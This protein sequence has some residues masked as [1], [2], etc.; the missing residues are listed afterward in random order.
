MWKT[1]KVIYEEK[2][3]KSSVFPTYSPTDPLLV[4]WVH[5]AVGGGNLKKVVSPNYS[6]TDPLLDFEEQNVVST[7]SEK[8]YKA[9][10]QNHPHPC[11]R[12]EVLQNGGENEHPVCV[13]PLRCLRLDTVLSRIVL[14]TYHLFRVYLR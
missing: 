13:D 6:P 4:N 9:R 3:L 5:R 14:V 2:Y 11:S 12:L 1:K 8:S 7:I 10:F